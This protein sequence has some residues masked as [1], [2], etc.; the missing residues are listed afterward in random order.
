MW[1]THMPY[2]FEQCWLNDYTHKISPT[3]NTKLFNYLLVINSL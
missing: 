3:T 2:V 1:R